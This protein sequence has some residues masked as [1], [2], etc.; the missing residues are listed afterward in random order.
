MTGFDAA[1]WRAAHVA[2]K[3]QHAARRRLAQFA[4]AVAAGASFATLALHGP[5]APMADP[6]APPRH[7]ASAADCV[8]EGYPPIVWAPGGRRWGCVSP[9]TL[10]HMDAAARTRQAA[11]DDVRAAAETGREADQR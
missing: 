6:A 3:R 8:G 9:E 11:R 2:R 10:T 4:L 7:V 5:A 1:G